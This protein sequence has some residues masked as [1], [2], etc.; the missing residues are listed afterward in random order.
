[1]CIVL[2]F[3]Y[4]KYCCASYLY[5]CLSYKR[6]NTSLLRYFSAN[7]PYTT[8]MLFT[9][10]FLSSSYVLQ[11]T[12]YTMEIHYFWCIFLFQTA[13]SRTT[14]CINLS[15]LFSSL[16]AWR[17]LKKI[18][19]PDKEI[20]FHSRIQMIKVRVATCLRVFK[21]RCSSK[22]TYGHKTWPT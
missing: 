9:R 18:N 4:V 13:H 20:D 6:Y 7:V 1:M 16:Q 19:A 21:V 5:P 3:F 11:P 2:L 22:W 14:F 8:S 10:I 12:L 17:Y 15:V